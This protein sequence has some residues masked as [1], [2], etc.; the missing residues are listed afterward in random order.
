MRPYTTLELAKI[1]EA[2]DIAE[3]EADRATEDMPVYSQDLSLAYASK[4][5]A[6]YHQKIDEILAAQGIRRTTSIL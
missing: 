3:S 1:N 4:W 6:V 2:S 5:N